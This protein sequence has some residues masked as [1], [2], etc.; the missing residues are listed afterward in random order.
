MFCV[1]TVMSD[2][3]LSIIT[4][5]FGLLDFVGGEEALKKKRKKIATCSCK[6]LLFTFSPQHPPHPPILP[7]ISNS[8]L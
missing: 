2:F 5:T 4:S 3:F 8:Q 7:P 6:P 1:A